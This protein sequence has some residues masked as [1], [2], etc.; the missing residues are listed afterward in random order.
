MNDAH[1]EC[2]ILSM[3]KLIPL[4]ILMLLFLFP[5][6]ATKSREGYTDQEK[7]T[8]LLVLGSDMIDSVEA[9]GGI[10]VEAFE[11]ALP[12]SFTAYDGFSPMYQSL[13]ASYSESLSETVS[14]MLSEA[15]PVLR[16]ALVEASSSDMDT[17]IASPE[18]MTDRLQD[19][20]A[21]E[22]YSLFIDSVESIW[23]DAENAFS[24]A[25]GIFLSVKDSYTNLESVGVGIS[26]PNPEGF[27]K[28]Q[29]AFVAEDYLFT[30]LG[31]AERELKSRLPDNP[32]SPY[33]VFWEETI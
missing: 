11:E 33:S 3:R 4:L 27:S 30:Q 10:K 22:I 28:D 21:V 16:E 7:Q 19:I 1:A 5:S 6:C 18:G 24:E 32:D 23:A 15:Y 12:P 13:A 17:A 29:L 2:R 9:A 25:E 20:A 31:E 8:A 26:L 14:P